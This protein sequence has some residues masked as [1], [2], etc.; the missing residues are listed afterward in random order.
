MRYGQVHSLRLATFP[1]VSRG[2]HLEG[3]REGEPRRVQLAPSRS[4]DGT[5]E[6]TRPAKTQPPPDGHATLTTASDPGRQA[7]AGLNI[8]DRI[9]KPPFRFPSPR[10]GSESLCQHIRWPPAHRSP[11]L[12][13]V[14]CAGDPEVARPGNGGLWGRGFRRSLLASSR[15]LERRRQL[16]GA[17]LQTAAAGAQRGGRPPARVSVSRPASFQ[18]A[19]AWKRGRWTRM[20][21]V[22]TAKA[23]RAL[24]WPTRR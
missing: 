9:R 12:S 4:T 6:P 18:G 24:W 17:F 13:T 1:V 11:G 19:G 3:G 5:A 15:G 23:T 10:F 21:G 8:R 2:H 14:R 22:T 20:N 7:A 16:T